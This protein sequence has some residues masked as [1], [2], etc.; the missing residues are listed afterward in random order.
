ML[1]FNCNVA[2]GQFKDDPWLLRRAI[3]YLDGTLVGPRRVKPGMAQIT[4]V[5]DAGLDPLARARRGQAQ[6]QTSGRMDLIDVA[7]LRGAAR[8]PLR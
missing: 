5:V 1:C 2:I 4:K 8:N 6:E 7:A 3:A